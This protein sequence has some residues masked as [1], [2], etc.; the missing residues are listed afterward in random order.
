MRTFEKFNPCGAPCP[1]CGGFEEDEPAVLIP[2]LDTEHGGICM[3]KQFHL[4]CLELAYSSNQS[5]PGEVLVYMVFD[6]K[7]EQ[8]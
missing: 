4:R 7:G 8:Q 5:V 6:E 1:V 3:A 2:M